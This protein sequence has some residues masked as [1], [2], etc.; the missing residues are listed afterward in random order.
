MIR[1]FVGYI[2]EALHLGETPQRTAV[3]F[4]L[5]VFIA[6]TPTYGLHCASAVFLAWAFRLNF[7]ALLVGSLINNPW[8]IAPIVGTTMW[9]GFFLLGRPEAPDVA[10]KNLSII[11]IYESVLPFILP[12][13][14][15][16]LTLSVLGALLAYP[17]G[18]LVIAR[19]RKTTRNATGPIAQKGPT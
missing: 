7:P 9:T 5:G 13:T 16:A 11:T 14:L 19:Y 18:L 1:K 4:A 17:L 10:W 12:F 15:G 6:F 2:K 8:T 3:A